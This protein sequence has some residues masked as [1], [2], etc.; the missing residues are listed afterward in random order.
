MPLESSDILIELA[1]RKAARERLILF[2]KYTMPEYDINWHH[3]VEA[4]KLEQFSRGEIKNL[5]IFA[6]PQTGKSELSTRR[7]PCFHLG[8][9]PDSRIIVS[10]YNQTFASYFNRDMQRIITGERYKAL[11][12]GTRL[13]AKNTV[14][15]A[16]SNYLKNSDIFEVVGRKGFVRTAG[17][18]SA[19][20]GLP[21]DIGIIDDPIK[22]KKEAESETYR[23]ANWEWYKNVFKTRFHNGT[24]QLITLTRWHDDDLA[25]RILR[26]ERDKWTV[27]KLPAINV[28][29][30]SDD[31]PRE[32]GEALWPARQALEM[33]EDIRE[34]SPQTF[35]PLY[36]QEPGDEKGGIVKKAYLQVVSIHDIPAEVFQQRIDFTIDTAF[37]AKTS[38]DPSGLM[39][40]TE[41]ENNLYIFKWE[42]VRLEFS[43]LCDRIIAFRDM[44]GTKESKIYVEPKANGKSVVQYLKKKT[45]L[46]I[47]EY[48]MPD[49]DKTGRLYGV[50]PYL[51]S[52]R[53]FI[54]YGSWNEPFIYEAS[55]YPNAAHDEA[56]DNLTMAITQ[57]LV[58]NMFKGRKKG[59]KTRVI[60]NE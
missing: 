56:I 59:R 9:K 38:G 19:L 4:N 11:F 17:I 5:M 30:K 21:A 26:E 7:F 55:M 33:L 54:I 12:P 36:Q 25:G 60:N 57:G 37:T 45:N 3:E 53:V 34:K 52:G 32:P 51:A 39:A 44:Y 14:T 22:D 41:F 42:S 6:P 43:D 49:G 48:Q 24:Q 13:N 20:T 23:D 35:T 50:E 18:G 10:A 47:M 1:I 31:D 40:Y 58:R 15:D 29:G 16:N 2:T 27:L 8:N 28:Y 46:N